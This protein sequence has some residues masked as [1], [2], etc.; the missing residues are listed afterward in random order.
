LNSFLKSTGRR[1]HALETRLC[2]LSH[3]NNLGQRVASL[4]Q[5][6]PSRMIDDRTA[7]L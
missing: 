3:L 4:M 6:R 1:D 7:L 2:D 5:S